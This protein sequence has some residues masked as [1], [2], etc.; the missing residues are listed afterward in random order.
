VPEPRSCKLSC[1]HPQLQQ[2]DSTVDGSQYLQSM[3]LSHKKGD[4]AIS[5]WA[6][7][8]I[9]LTS[10][11]DPPIS[12]VLPRL[13]PSTRVRNVSFDSS[14]PQTSSSNGSH[15]LL[16]Y[17]PTPTKLRSPCK[18]PPIA[19]PTTPPFDP[20]SP[21]KLVSPSK[22]KPTIPKAPNLRPSLDAFWDPEVVN[23]WN[24]QHSPSKTLV[25]PRKQKWREDIVKTMES[26]ALDDDASSSDA[27]PPSPS[28][29]PQ[30]K[31]VNKYTE[32]H[33]PL[34]KTAPISSTNPSV[35]EIR[36][37][38]KAFADQKHD[39]AAAFLT[40]LDTTICEGRIFQL[41]EQ[42]GGIK[43]VWSRTLKTTAGR[44]NWRREQIRIRTGPLP[45]DFK[46]E[47]RHHCSID[48]AEKVIDDEERLHNVLAHE[49]CHLTT[50][51]LSNVRNNPHGAEFKAWG[52]RATAAFAHR[53]VE[54]TT[55]HSYAIDYKFVWE[56]VSC[57]YEFK[58]HSKSVDTSRHSCGKC[59]G[60]LVQTKP[61]PRAVKETSEY[62]L[63]IKANFARVKGE[64]ESKGEN[65]QMGK[66]MEAVAKEYREEQASKM[67]MDSVRLEEALEGL[68]I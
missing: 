60:K 23:D 52:R 6:Q 10:L 42:T 9:N 40:E 12:F 27:D 21:S 8:V 41:T 19:R 28:T 54:V 50:F 35:K 16:T 58:R 66:V 43:L 18:A 20:S 4:S 3:Q 32:P 39:I 47:I 24:E 11:P 56:C 1:T 45:S 29:S 31:K 22:K 55:K 64:M 63:F 44:A 46:T 13:P 59:K 67:A 25:S 68:Q 7:D 51:M 26:I 49:F 33:S 61:V 5:S 62:Q 15:A 57:G 38:R 30:K 53:G 2:E 34:K 36:A 48:L 65:T 37:Q 14:R 17:S